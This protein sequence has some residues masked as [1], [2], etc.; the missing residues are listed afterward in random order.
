MRLDRA[1]KMLDQLLASDE[2]MAAMYLTRFQITGRQDPHKEHLQVSYFMYMYA[3]F[4]CVC[5][6]CLYVCMYTGDEDM[7]AIYLTRFQMAGRQDPPKE[8]L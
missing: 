4:I 1:L 6:V 8:H 5:V 7:A 3:F 2:D